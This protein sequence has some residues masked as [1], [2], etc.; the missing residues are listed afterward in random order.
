MVYSHGSGDVSVRIE[1]RAQQISGSVDEKFPYLFECAKGFPESAVWLVLSGDGARKRAMDWL[2]REA[3][4][5][6]EKTIRV[7]TELE[8][9]SAVKALV[10]DGIANAFAKANRR[11][12]NS[13]PSWLT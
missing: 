2:K 12:R 8:A 3:H 10:D 4:S 7:Y 6:K 13:R 1:C 9:I 11:G 5:Y